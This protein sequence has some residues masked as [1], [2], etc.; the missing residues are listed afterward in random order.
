MLY[1]SLSVCHLYLQSLPLWAMG[2]P[3]TAHPRQL[4]QPPCLVMAVGSPLPLYFRTL[5][6]A[7]LLALS[8]C[9][10]SRRLALQED[11]E[12]MLQC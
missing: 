8:L 11:G 9:M 2:F 4:R 7:Y 6:I 12:K 10:S 3:L 5:L 1:L